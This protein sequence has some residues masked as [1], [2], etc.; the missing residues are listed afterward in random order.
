[1]QENF[2]RKLLREL[3]NVLLTVAA[4]LALWE[5]AARLHLYDVSFFP[6]PSADANA[7]FSSVKSG[8]LIS[9]TWMSLRRALVGFIAGSC[10]GAA[11]GI[12][13]GRLR[14]VDSTLGQVIKVLR[15]IPTIA[16]VPLAIVWFGLG[17]TSKYLLVFWGVFFPVWVSSHIGAAEV[18]QTFI[19]AARS[20][21]ANTWRLL[22][23]VILPG[24]APH[25]IGGMRTGIATAFV[26]L[27]AAEMTGAFGGLGYRI[28]VSHLVFRVDKMVVDIVVLGAIGALTDVVFASIISLIP[29]SPESAK[30]M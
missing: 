13:T 1:M 7:L 16:L 6:P 11:A 8:E 2:W 17:E 27:M 30:R 25:I 9:D 12:L 28:Y 10:V 26:V 19:W 15:S 21:G 29:W 4:L 3:T 5:A 20:L 14:I 24:A 18:D 22:C 23:E